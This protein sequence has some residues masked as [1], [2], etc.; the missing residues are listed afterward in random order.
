MLPPAPPHRGSAMLTSLAFALLL[1]VPPTPELAPGTR[2]DPAIPTLEQ[3]AGHGITEAMTWPEQIV[4]YF[5]ALAGAAPQ[6]TRLVDLGRSWEGRAMVMLVIGSPERM[7]RLDEVKADLKR[8][9]DP[10]GLL[11]AEADRLVRDLPVVSA[12][13]HGVHGNEMSSGGAAMAQA[14][15]LLAAQGDPAVDLI[16]RESLVLIDPMQNPDGRARF[17]FQNQLGA[18]RWPDAEP[19]SAEHDEPWPGGRG[20]HYLF[21]LNRDWFAQTQ[22]E[23]RGRVAALLDFMPHIVSDLHEM[24]GNSTYYFPPNAVPGNT[25]TT[26][27]QRG[28]S[29][30]LGQAMAKAFDARGFAYFNR[31]TYDAFYPG[32]GVSWPMAQGAIGATYEMASSRGLVYRRSD[33]DLLTYGDGILRHFTAAMATLHAAAANRERVL[34]T[35]LEF[36]RSAV[37]MG[38]TGPREYVLHSSQDPGMATR[39]AETL[40]ANGI[41]VSRATGSVQVG[42]RTLP[43]QGTYIVPMD[44][45]AHRLARNLLDRHTPMDEDFVALQVERR[46]KRMSDQIY[47]V[48]AWSLPL[49]WDV[50]LLLAMR[51]TGASVEPVR[52]TGPRRDATSLPAA[53]VGYLI[54]WS[55]DGAAAVGEALRSGIRVR[56]SGGKFTLG[57]RA[58]GVGTAIV[59]TAENGPDLARRLAAIAAEHGVEVVPVDDSYVREGTSLGSG[60][61]RALRPPRVLL[62]W[63]QP[64]SSNSAGWARYVLERRYGQPVTAVR[65]AALGRATLSDYDVIVFPSGSFGGAV[66]Q[67]LVERLQAWMRDGGTVITMAESTA[68]ASRAGLLA[69]KAE[70]RGGRPEGTP[71][72]AKKAQEQPIDWLEAIAPADEAPEQTPGAILR[73]LLDTDHWLAAGTDGDIGA[74]VEGSRVFTPITLD[75]GTNVGRYAGE[76]DLVLSGIVWDDARPQLANK[77]FLIHQPVGRGQLVAFAEDPTYR[78]Y[79]ETTELLFMNAVLLGPGR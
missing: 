5:R 29:E 78:A 8:L 13:I 40:V 45:P 42:G 23:T 21:D 10:R 39:L 75:A 54:P 38:Q 70:R 2:Y 59:R 68:W 37:A 53:Q 1:Q 7:A 31:D 50:E 71:A 24:G 17:L 28:L 22:P 60:G 49:L 74:M 61:N 48:T 4:A 9:A 44:Q 30:M 34:R 58:F 6:R 62:V 66:G 35:F 73:V 72:P 41:E 67:A 79:A 77:A 43:A 63:D 47:D 16:L 20:N 15:H 55:T 27:E 3:V 19:L 69:T 36:R 51:P 26:D 64:S 65:A 11:P 52:A 46:A 25:W 12:M 32:Y 57:G 14:Y 76:D 56:T 18:A 33:G